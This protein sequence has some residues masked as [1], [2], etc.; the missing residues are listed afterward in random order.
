MTTTSCARSAA[1]V[2]I[3]RL[4]LFGSALRGELRPKSDIDLLVEF[5]PDEVPG[6]LGI[7]QIELELG[8][9]L[10]QEVDLR[11]RADL[12]RH[13]RDRVAATARVLIDAA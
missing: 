13:F 3:R 10:R 11:T 7:A 12:C 5:D 1:L 8:Q 6:L 4:N 2:G 9:L